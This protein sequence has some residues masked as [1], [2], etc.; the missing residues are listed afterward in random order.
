M[1]TCLIIIITD[2]HVV[3]KVQSGIPTP[4]AH[5]LW[6]SED[7]YLSLNEN[8]PQARSLIGTFPGHYK[9][10]WLSQWESLKVSKV[11]YKSV[12]ML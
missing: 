1:Y 6:E 11:G 5:D 2:W 8:I 4:D 12:H 3:F 9:S 7:I 10:S